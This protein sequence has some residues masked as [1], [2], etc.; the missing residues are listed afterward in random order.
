[1]QDFEFDASAVTDM[2]WKE[3]DDKWI[4][5]VINRYDSAQKA[6]TVCT[7]SLNFTEPYLRIV[8][9]DRYDD[10]IWIIQS[11]TKISNDPIFY[12][13]SYPSGSPPPG[14]PVIMTLNFEL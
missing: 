2:G 8:S 3:I 9:E 14:Q 12:E 6:G 5:Y 7:F 13:I 11:P 10:L 4:L 1:L